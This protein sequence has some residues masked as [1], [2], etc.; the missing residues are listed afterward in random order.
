MSAP[1]MCRLVC[2]SL[3]IYHGLIVFNQKIIH[4]NTSRLILR[5]T[6]GTSVRT[7]SK[8][9]FHH[10]NTSKARAHN[11][12]RSDAVSLYTS[13]TQHF[14][15]N[16]TLSYALV[17]CQ[18]GTTYK[19]NQ[20]PHSHHRHCWR[21]REHDSSTANLPSAVRPACDC[22]PGT[23]CGSRLNEDPL[24]TVAENNKTRTQSALNVWS[25]L[26]VRWECSTEAGVFSD[27]RRICF[28]YVDA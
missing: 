18:V 3:Y 1:E 2:C 13:H 14:L 8:I 17:Q 23:V 22:P 28:G 25:S 16:R 4:S 19:Q 12:P 20:R 10:T 6:P 24:M 26:Y 11:A 15:A 27:E 5:S 7:L 21:R 9:M